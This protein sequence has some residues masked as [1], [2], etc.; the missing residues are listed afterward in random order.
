MQFSVL[1]GTC[2]FDTYVD[3]NVNSTTGNRRV[4]LRETPLPIL[5]TVKIRRARRSYLTQSTVIIT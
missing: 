5:D 1:N 3:M 4:T 2:I